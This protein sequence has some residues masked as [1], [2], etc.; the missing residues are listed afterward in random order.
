MSRTGQ[1]ELGALLRSPGFFRLW[2]IGL[3]GNSMRWLEVLAAALFTLDVTGSGLAV[4]VVSAARTMPMLLFGAL[5]GVV[6]EAVDRKRLLLAALAVSALSAAVVAA[7]AAGGIARPWHL[8]LAGFVSGTVWSTEMSTRRRMV[9]EVAGQR[10]ARAMALDSVTGSTTRMIGPLL[11]GVG[12]QLVG[13]PGAYAFSAC[14]YLLGT[15]LVLGLR[16]EQVPHRLRLAR[17]PA[18]L[19]EGFAFARANTMVLCVLGITIAMNLCGF[20][21]TALVAPI[22]REVFDVSPALVGVLAAAEPFGCLI[23]GLVLAGWDVRLGDRR[24][25]AGGSALFLIVLM[26]MPFS[27][28]F[29]LALALLWLG[30][31][32]TAAFS[33]LQST[34]ILTAAPPT[35][36]SRLMGILTVCIGTGPLGLLLIGVL[37]D[38]FGPRLA[39]VIM[40][41]IGLAGVIAVGLFWARHD[42][43]AGPPVSP[44][45]RRKTATDVSGIR[46][47]LQRRVTSGEIAVRVD[48]LEADMRGARV[49]MRVQLAL[50]RRGV[51][52]GDHRVDEPVVAAIG[53]LGLGEADAEPVVAIIGQAHVARQ[54]LAAERAGFRGVGLQADLLL[55]GEPFRRTEDRLGLLGV[56]GR[57][58]VRQRAARPLRR[59]RQHLRPQRGDGDGPLLRAGLTLGDAVEIG[60]HRR[61]RLLVLVARAAPRPSGCD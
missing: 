48:R 24:Q 59:Q 53:E 37:A 15:I 11:G 3:A 51:A 6:S 45:S 41:A 28:A 42:R 38:E 58:V 47:R 13:L 23:G 50:D 60:A 14:M 49:E 35:M 40:A 20:A 36:R 21:Y 55:D 19:G 18:D 54:L 12:Y 52:P 44:R 56:L 26:L 17:V 10:I 16:H 2:M 34:L 22:G 32:G 61:D 8:A 33:N 25:F 30:G 9:G 27:P 39:L 29:S 46:Q 43:R 57:D 4:A 31:F 1:G 5:A 7:L